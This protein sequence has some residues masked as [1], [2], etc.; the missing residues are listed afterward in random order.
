M[1]A[2][3]KGG[4]RRRW[5]AWNIQGGRDYYVRLA[6]AN[7]NERVRVAVIQYAIDTLV[8]AKVLIRDENGAMAAA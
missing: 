7:P 3:A 1:K 8:E 6:E 2:C 4:W 5:R